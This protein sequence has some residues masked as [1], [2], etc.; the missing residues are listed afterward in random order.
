MKTAHP[1][2]YC[3]QESEFCFQTLDHNQRISNV[4][5]DYFRC[6]SCDLI[7]ISPIPDDLE[8]YYPSSY[9]QLSTDPDALY[10]IHHKFEGYK[11][12][13]IAQFAKGK[14]LLEI[15][16]GAGGF[17]YLAKRAGYQMSV[18]EM[19]GAVCE[20]M[21]NVLRIPA[22]HTADVVAGIENLGQFDVIAL[23]HVI[24]H[25]PDLWRVW[26]ALVEH[27][28]PN[29]I[30]VLAAPNPDALQ[31]KI[32]Q[33]YWTHIDA[34]RHVYLIPMNLLIKLA[35]RDHLELIEQT[36]T[37]A[38]TLIWNKFGWQWSMRNFVRHRAQMKIPARLVDL[39][40]R[41]I[42]RPRHR[43]TTY[44]LIFRKTET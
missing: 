32:W 5:F 42:E 4:A 15:G 31:L 9:Y 22:V 36:T 2:P 23:W 27:L 11:I 8:H 3:Q 39:L 38:G 1:C 18:I 13:M 6:Q 24:E 40:M 17:A 12:E 7:F 37:D 16:P 21:E 19:D 10:A 30:L 14:R 26:D 35:Q 25:M 29:G 34:P 33:Q 44:T 20:Y 41:P 43:G 28:A